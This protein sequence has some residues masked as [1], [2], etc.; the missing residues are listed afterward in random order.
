ME[1][2]LQILKYI[3]WT[4]V[5]Q[6]SKVDG[7][8][9]SIGIN[10]LLIY[11]NFHRLTY[12]YMHGKMGEGL[13]TFKGLHMPIYRIYMYR[14]SLDVVYLQI[15]SVYEKTRSKISLHIG[16]FCHFAQ[17]SSVDFIQVEAST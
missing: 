11:F 9:V 7:G 10:H 16:T 2:Y 15:L 8:L 13:H 3:T 12:P 5:S 6:N 1:C 17:C 4:V 14:F